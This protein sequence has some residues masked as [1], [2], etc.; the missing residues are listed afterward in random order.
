MSGLLVDERCIVIQPSLIR[1]LGN[2]HDAAILQQL[3]YWMPRATSTY[4]GQRWVYKTYDQWGDEVGLTAKQVRQAIARLEGA[5]VVASCQPEAWQ[6][7]KWYRIV[8]DHSL[9]SPSAQMGTCNR[10][11]GQNDVPYKAGPSAPQ[12]CSI[13]ESTQESTHQS[14]DKE[15]APALQSLPSGGID[16][17][18]EITKRQSQ[19]AEAERLAGLLADLIEANGTRRPVVTRK[20]VQTIDR[21]MRLDDRTPKQIESA[22][23]WA[24]GHEFWSTNILS[25]DALRRQYDR[26]RL[27]AQREQRRP[28]RGIDGVRQFLDALD[29]AGHTVVDAGGL[30]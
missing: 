15:L 14:T 26:L 13:T 30:G 12:G 18:T 6:R 10:P 25:P 5:G 17:M 19:L 16:S 28:V 9:L 2:M 7:R 22:M 24:L 23:R 8:Y 1:R 4:D 3:H 20:W 21:M 29:E 27:Q 11:D